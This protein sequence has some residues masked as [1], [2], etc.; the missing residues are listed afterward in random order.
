[1]GQRASQV[2]AL[3]FD[4]VLRAARDALLGERGAA[5]TS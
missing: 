4:D 2:G 5:S 1:M 3:N